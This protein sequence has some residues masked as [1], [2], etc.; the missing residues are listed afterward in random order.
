MAS[1]S[2]SERETRY[3]LQ[4]TAEVNM[5]SLPPLP[6]YIS[7]R[8]SCADTKGTA[9]KCSGQTGCLCA[10]ATLWGG[11][12]IGSRHTALSW[13]MTWWSFHVGTGS[14]TVG[15]ESGGGVEG[16]QE[17]VLEESRGQKDVKYKD[18]YCYV[19]SRLCSWMVGSLSLM[20]CSLAAWDTHKVFHSGTWSWAGGGGGG[21]GRHKVSVAGYCRLLGSCPAAYETVAY[22]GMEV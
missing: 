9:G 16:R 12:E 14:R 22:G 8:W 10:A 17:G 3:T 19:V 4:S 13:P 7:W 11:A 2:G 5:W 20:W 21:G 15:W 1:I 6:V 18:V